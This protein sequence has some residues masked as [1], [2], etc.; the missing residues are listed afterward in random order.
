MVLEA[1]TCGLD[2]KACSSEDCARVKLVAIHVLEWWQ[3]RLTIVRCNE[4]YF[5]GAVGD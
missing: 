1:Y 5:F 2:L 4:L 3:I